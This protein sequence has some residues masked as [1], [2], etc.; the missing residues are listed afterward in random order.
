MPAAVATRASLIAGAM[1]PK[2]ELFEPS[3]EKVSKIPITVPNRPI[4]G[5]VDAIIE[6]MVSPL[7]ALRTV[8]LMA[9]SKI[10]LFAKVVR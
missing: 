9:A 7:V 1:T 8:S 5:E 10:A 4:N 2:E 6:S 3:L